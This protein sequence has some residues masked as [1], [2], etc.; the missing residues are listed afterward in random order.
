MP[1]TGELTTLGEYKGT[2][3]IGTPLRA[4]LCTH[5][6]IYVLPL[7]TILMAK[8]TGV[9]TSVPSDS[10][11]DFIA[12]ED[13]KKKPKLREKFGVKDEWVLPFEA[14]PII[15]VPGFGTTAAPKVCSG[16]IV[17]TESHNF[18]MHIDYKGNIN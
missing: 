2:D 4:P 8:G 10:P 1:A 14:V 15:D 11:T 3:L 9:V 6:K 17:M 13:L 5:Q 12:L 16:F 7:L 18:K